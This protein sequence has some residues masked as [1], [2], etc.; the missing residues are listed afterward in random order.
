[1]ELNEII[2][3][4]LPR[5]L[6]AKNENKWNYLTQIAQAPGGKKWNYNEIIWPK[7]PIGP[8]WQKMEQQEHEGSEH[9]LVKEQL[10]QITNLFF[11]TKCLYLCYKSVKLLLRMS[12]N[13]Y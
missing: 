3:P 8:W 4:K 6:V 1:M 2:W 10:H 5:P 13:N 11:V 12:Q 7:F 9:L